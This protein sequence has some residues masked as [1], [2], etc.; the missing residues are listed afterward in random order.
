MLNKVNQIKIIEL[1]ISIVRLSSNRRSN[2]TNAQD[3]GAKV[4]TLT[5]IAAFIL[6]LLIAAAM[7]CGL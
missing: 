3:V 4:G 7:L 1:K 5:S 2:M 6:I